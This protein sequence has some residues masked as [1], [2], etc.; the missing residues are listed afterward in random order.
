MTYDGFEP[1]WKNDIESS[2]ASLNWSSQSSSGEMT[3]QFR[4]GNVCSVCLFC[5]SNSRASDIVAADVVIG[6]LTVKAKLRVS[7]CSL[8]QS[9]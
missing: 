1:M 5:A 7:V 3:E 8:Q 6:D 9:L 2:N 4:E